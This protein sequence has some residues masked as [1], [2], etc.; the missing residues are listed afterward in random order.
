MEN[1]KLKSDDLFIISLKVD[2]GFQLS[3]AGIKAPF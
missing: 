2:D 1:S 3:L